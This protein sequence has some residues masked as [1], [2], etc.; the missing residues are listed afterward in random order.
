MGSAQSSVRANRVSESLLPRLGRR[1]AR[2]AA[3]SSR[4]QRHGVGANGGSGWRCAGLSPRTAARGVPEPA[5]LPRRRVPGL[6]P[7]LSYFGG[8][9]IPPS[10]S[11]LLSVSLHVA[12]VG[13]R[14]LAIGGTEHAKEPDAERQSRHAFAA[15]SLTTK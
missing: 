15:T 6:T 1:P 2:V 13:R 8:R 12:H 7:S 5:R 9:G 3:V 11:Q 10:I 14:G 4:A